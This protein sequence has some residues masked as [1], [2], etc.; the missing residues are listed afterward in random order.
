MPPRLSVLMAVH[1][2]DQ[3]VAEA[4][5][6]VLDQTFADFELIVMDDGSTDTTG[7]VLGGY[8]DPRLRVLRQPRAGLTLSLN[9]G[10]GLTAAPLVARMDAD[11]V[12][13][14]ERFAR[15]LA[16]L[17]AHSEVGLLGT[18]CQEISL[19]GVLLRTISPPADDRAIRRA[20]I[21]ENPFIHSSVIFRRSALAGAGSYD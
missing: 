10:L 16:F 3:L 15:Q 9:R 17:D 11:D 1:N 6:S 8:S 18:G 19:S 4:V 14:P 5:G 2:A 7:A 12:S 21:R 20:L 13:L